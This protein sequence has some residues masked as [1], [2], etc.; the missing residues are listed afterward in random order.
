MTAIQEVDLYGLETVLKGISR[1][2]KEKGEFYENQ[3]DSVNYWQPWLDASEYV[4]ECIDKVH[5]L[6][7]L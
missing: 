3:G 4:Q 2:C 6:N 5:Q 7:L 1:Y